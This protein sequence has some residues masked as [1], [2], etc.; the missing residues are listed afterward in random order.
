MDANEALKKLKEGNERF[1]Q[2]KPS[3]KDYAKRRAQLLSGQHPYATVLSCSDSRVV[4][5]Y[6][7]DADMGEIFIIRNAGDLANDPITLG[8]IEY[9]VE[10]TH[11]PLLVVMAHQFCGAVAATCAC[12]GISDEGHI[13]DIVESINSVAKKHEYNPEKCVIECTKETA[14]S[15]PEKSAV[16]KNLVDAGKL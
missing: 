11:T 15:L 5:E 6:I 14:K 12:K 4:P 8:S 16:V 3:Q 1:V 10:H 13:K 9:G 7:F 2:G